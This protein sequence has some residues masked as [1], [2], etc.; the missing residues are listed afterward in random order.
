MEKP[1]GAPVNGTGVETLPAEGRIA[2][3]S[4]QPADRRSRRRLRVLKRALIVYGGGLCTMRCQI[5]SVSDG[6]AMIRPNDIRSCPNEFLLKPES[7]DGRN[8][9]VVWRNDTVLGVR[10]V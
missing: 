7:G 9:H 10:F 8:C 5:F 4:E 3:P 2:K 6:G 1:A